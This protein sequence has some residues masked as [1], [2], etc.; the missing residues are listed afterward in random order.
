MTGTLV[1]LRHGQSTWNELNLFTGWHDVELTALGEREAAQAGKLMASEGLRFD[2]GH[3]SVLTRA[4]MTCHLALREM[5]TT[6]IEMIRTAARVRDL[7]TQMRWCIRA[8]SREH[9]AK[10]LRSDPRSRASCSVAAIKAAATKSALEWL[11]S[12]A[13][14]R[15]DCEIDEYGNF[16]ASR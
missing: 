10:W 14:S 6:V 8:S 3:T 2:F 1:L 12:S 7:P 5:P 13:N 15:S 4:V 11:I 16:A 9:C